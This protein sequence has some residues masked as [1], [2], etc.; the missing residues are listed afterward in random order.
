M[1]KLQDGVLVL[2][3]GWQYIAVAT[4]QEAIK[5]LFTGVS[6]AVDPE[7][8]ATYTFEDWV[9]RGVKPGKPFIQT[10]RMRVEI[11]EVIVLANFDKVPRK[12]F[13]YSK[14]HVYRR[15]HH[16]CQ[17]C[18]QQLK[19]EQLTI[20]HVIPRSQGG[21][22]S[23]V[24]CVTSCEPCNSKKADRTPEQA[25]MKMRRKPVKP[26]WSV[27]MAVRKM[28]VVRKASWSKFIHG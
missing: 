3:K 12:S 22:T 28:R 25:G 21:Q 23:W 26:E 15:D 9:E 13:H 2:N 27:E 16:T 20:D 6:T 10:P 7:T 14:Y 1:S 17:Y 19:R 5:D 4:V 8:Y 18:G 11:P 24:N